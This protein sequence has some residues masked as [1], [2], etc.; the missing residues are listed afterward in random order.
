MSKSL[1]KTQ[2][3]R[4]QHI[5]DVLVDLEKGLANFHLTVKKKKDKTI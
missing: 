3:N 1:K 5:E 4:E 2:K